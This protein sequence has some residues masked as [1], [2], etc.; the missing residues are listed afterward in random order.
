MIIMHTHPSFHA[1]TTQ[2]AAISPD[3]P[4]HHLIRRLPPVRGKMRANAE[5]SRSN[6]FQVGG[7]AEVLFK[8]E[9]T[10]DLMQFLQQKPADVPVTILGVGSNVIVRDGGLDG[11]VIRLGRGFTECNAKGALLKVGAAC[12]DVHVAALAQ[13]AGLTGL[14]FLSGI[15]GTIGGALRMNAGAYGSDI[16][17]VLISA[18]AVDAEGNQH[19]LTPDDF[20]YGYRHCHLPDGWIFTHCMLRG[21]IGD[22]TRIAETMQEIRNQR[23]QTQPIH[24]RTGGSTFKNPASGQ[25]A[26]ELIDAAGCRGLRV[27]DAQVSELHCNFL[28]N[29]GS[30]TAQDLETLGEEVL[31]RVKAHS[32]ITLEWEIKRIGTS[33]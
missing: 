10:A 12:L 1:A 14:E 4:A 11:V 23:E 31:Q 13:E 3:I 27:G 22:P 17:R 33:L 18:E 21:E 2:M 32:G 24:S 25:K 8:P 15:P 28:I 16:A 19:H 7:Q 9:D 5:L 30:A 29:H 20:G 26:W 6:W